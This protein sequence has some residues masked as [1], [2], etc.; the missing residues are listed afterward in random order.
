MVPTLGRKRPRVEIP[1]SVKK[2]IC[3]IKLSQPN[4]TILD[5]KQSIWEE[6]NINIGKSTIGDILKASK[7][8]LTIPEDCVEFTRARHARHEQLEEAVFSWLTYMTSH[9]ATVSDEMLVEKAREFGEQLGIT[10]FA[11]SNGW[12]GRFKKRR[13]IKQRPRK[14]RVICSNANP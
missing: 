8:W 10:N 6:L 13:G 11:Y 7:R 4:I 14:G 9:Q 1:S 2:K 12:L 3:Q 5:L